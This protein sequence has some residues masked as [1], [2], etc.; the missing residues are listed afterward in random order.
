MQFYDKHIFGITH[1]NIHA[2]ANKEHP[3]C[4]VFRWGIRIIAKTASIHK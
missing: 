3:K 1:V 2:A 4:D